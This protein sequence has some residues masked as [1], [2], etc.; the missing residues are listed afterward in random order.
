M[1]VCRDS[2]S[3]TEDSPEV[4]SA[5]RSPS[6]KAVLPLDSSEITRT[7]QRYKEGEEG[8]DLLSWVTEPCANYGPILNLLCPYT[9]T[10]LWNFLVTSP[11]PP[12]VLEGFKKGD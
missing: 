12:L 6:T 9:L 11:P 2:S 10:F 7:R 4:A 5:L 1:G 8:D 3:L